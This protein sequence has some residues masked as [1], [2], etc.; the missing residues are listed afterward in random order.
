MRSI[1]GPLDGCQRA[2]HLL[3]VSCFSC[4]HGIIGRIIDCHIVTLAPTERAADVAK[5]LAH[6]R[7]D[8]TVDRGCPGFRPLEKTGN[9][10]SAPA[11]N[12]VGD[13]A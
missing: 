2:L 3:S 12:G 13:A 4:S 11:T 7:R 8:R 6:H 9:S 5:W 1:S 10:A